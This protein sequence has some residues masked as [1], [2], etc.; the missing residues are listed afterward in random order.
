MRHLVRIALVPVLFAVGAAARADTPTPALEAARG[1]RTGAL[2]APAA[3]RAWSEAGL[4]PAQ[5]RELV[6][7]LYPTAPTLEP[8]EH[9]LEL[10]DPHGTRTDLVVV[11]PGAPRADGRYGLLV[12]LHG[13][14]GQAD[15]LVPFA[16]RVAPPGYVVA[17]PTAQFLPPAREAEN[18]R[19]LQAF[20][21]AGADEDDPGDGDDERRQR[22]RRAIEQAHRAML[23]HWWGYE[24]DGFPLL[25]IDEVRRRVPVDPD[26]VLL[27]GYSMGGYGTWNV[28][29]RHPDLFAGVAPLAG[30]LSRR[31]NVIDRDE[32]VRALLHN[33]RRV[34]SFFVHGAQDRV[35]PARFSRTIHAELEA[36]GAEHVYEEVERGGHILRKFLQGDALT[37][38]L[39]AWLADRVRAP[40]ARR[41]EH[42]LLDAAHGHA[43]WLRVEA[44]TSTPARVTGEVHEGNRVVVETRGVA[45]LTV[46]LDPAL[47]DLS[48]PVRIEVDGRVVHDGPVAPSLEAVARSF[49]RRRDPSLVLEHAVTV[50]VAEAPREF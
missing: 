28:G 33:A 22:A 18:G 25:A 44:T 3:A 10:E 8:G 37:D 47:V 13:L 49:E 50:D 39:A 17:A 46:F 2:D 41:V 32:R 7:S 35:V 34:P 27:V 26:R 14:R 45:R 42:A 30:G 23:P 29:L 48:R 40:R 16:R 5:A 24:A 19:L 43:G 36:L 12:V 4:T 20:G 6:R 1:L 21:L 15:Q 31:E 9:R 38:R 11:V